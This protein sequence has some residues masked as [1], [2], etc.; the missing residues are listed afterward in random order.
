MVSV[1]MSDSRQQK[2]GESLADTFRI[3]GQYLY[4]DDLML[5]EFSK[6]KTIQQVMDMELYDDDVIVAS[7]PKTG[8]I[9]SSAKIGAGNGLLL[10]RLMFETHH[11]ILSNVRA[12]Q[13]SKVYCALAQ[14]FSV[15][16]MGRHPDQFIPDNNCKLAPN[17]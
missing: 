15:K 11:N 6:P 12:T 4:Q 10:P 17:G 9:P 7:Y 8:T 3:P 1:T 16:V 13:H 2:D 14:T 5:G